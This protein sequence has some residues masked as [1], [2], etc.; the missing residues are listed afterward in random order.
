MQMEIVGYLL[1]LF[2]AL[3]GIAVLW[4]FMM[5]RNAGAQGL[6]RSLPAEG[7]HGWRHGVVRY[8]G[9]EARFYKLRS[10]SFN[11]DRA[12]DRRYVTFNGMREVTEAEREIMPDIE[13]VLQL[14][15]PD[16]DFE[17]AG[18][19]PVEM[20]LI[21]WIESAPDSRTQRE[22]MNAL[23]ERANRGRRLQR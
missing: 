12:I 11:Y 17:F 6:V 15:G 2:C 10:L 20:A 5:F 21:S 16:G 7:V 19:Q 18:A 14:T 13:S 4:R 22:D 8:V 3:G 1:V 23:E 9:E